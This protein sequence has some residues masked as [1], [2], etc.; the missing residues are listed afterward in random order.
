MYRLVVY[1]LGVYVVLA[2][3]FSFMGRVSFSATAIVVSL[4]ALIVP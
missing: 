2:L 4:G 1:A 3:I